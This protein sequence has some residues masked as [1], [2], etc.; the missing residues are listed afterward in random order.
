MKNVVFGA[1]YRTMPQK[2]REFLKYV[3]LYSFW[4]KGYTQAEIAAYQKK[5]QQAVSRQL[6]T[7][8]RK[9]PQLFRQYKLDRTTYQ[10]DPNRDD[11]QVVEQF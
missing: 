11:N 9:Y 5:S 8:R 3:E 10:Y 2:R 6:N 4:Q 7:L 1:L